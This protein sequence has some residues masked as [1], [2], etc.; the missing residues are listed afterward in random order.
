MQKALSQANDAKNEG[1]KLFG[2]GKFEDALLQYE[3]A[4]QVAADMTSLVEIRSIC[5][6]NRAICCSKLVFILTYMMLLFVSVGW[7]FST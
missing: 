7:S 5:H 3:L 1:N 6:A 4:L 2:D